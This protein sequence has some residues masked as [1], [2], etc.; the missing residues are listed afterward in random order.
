M[1]AFP[2]WNKPFYARIQKDTGTRTVS[3]SRLFQLKFR[4]N[5]RR[6]SGEILRTRNTSED[7]SRKLFIRPCSVQRSVTWIL[8]VCIKNNWR[9]RNGTGAWS[10]ADPPQQVRKVCWWWELLGL[11]GERMRWS[12]YLQ[13]A[14]FVFEPVRG[15]ESF[16]L[17]VYQWQR[18]EHDDDSQQFNI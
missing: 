7:K 17:L 13:D 14:V 8:F 11:S 16:G 6:T 4:L 1:D 15:F 12:R 10:E 3:P 2:E 9:E 18:H 5:T